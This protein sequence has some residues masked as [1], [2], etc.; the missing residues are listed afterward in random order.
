MVST[1][2]VKAE[3][4]MSNQTM[5]GRLI[6]PAAQNIPPS[7]HILCFCSTRNQLGVAPTQGPPRSSAC[8]FQLLSIYP[9]ARLS[10]RSW[11]SRHRSIYSYTVFSF[12][13]EPVVRQQAAAAQFFLPLWCFSHLF[14]IERDPH[15]FDHCACCYPCCPLA[16]ATPCPTLPFNDCK[17][18]NYHLYQTASVLT[19][20]HTR[21]T[22]A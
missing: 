6:G 5:C 10:H 20:P 21:K 11:S 19:M 17:K 14:F 1:V 22:L 3:Y 8:C 16:A 9:R 15:S 4:I 2:T 12:D 7:T 18:W 13:P